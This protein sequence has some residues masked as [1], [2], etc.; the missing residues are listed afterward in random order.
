MCDYS[1]MGIPSR[2][3][4]DGEDLIVHEFPTGS[5]G[6]TPAA[7]TQAAPLATRSTIVSYMKK[8]FEAEPAA[9][10]VPPGARLLLSD[11]PEEMQISFGVGP[12]AE[13]TFTQLTARA[14]AYR[15]AVR[16]TNGR[17]VLLQRLP[18]GQRVKV[19]HAA[20][21]EDLGAVAEEPEYFD[22]RTTRIDFI[23]PRLLR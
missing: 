4:R 11:I 14:Y 20:L 1:L 13:V 17:E 2:L 21:T 7:K 6:L 18:E 8:L 12:V 23:A 9:I 19:L 15:D 16:F 10:C 5:R 3:A 22:F